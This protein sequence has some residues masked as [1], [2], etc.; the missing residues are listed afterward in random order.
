MS[1]VTFN[2]PQYTSNNG[3][4]RGP[5]PSLLSK[6]MI[7]FGFAKDEA[8]AQRALAISAGVIALLA[9]VVYVWSHS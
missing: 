5:E 7:S 8:G 4:G 3:S 9:I 2:E 1:D 6:L